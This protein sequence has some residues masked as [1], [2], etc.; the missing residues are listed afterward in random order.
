MHMI[1]FQGPLVGAAVGA[2]V[3]ELGEHV[4]PN[5]PSEHLSAL[6]RHA[7]QL[8]I[9]HEREIKLDPLNINPPHRGEPSV[10]AC[11]GQ[12]IADAR[13]QGRRQPSGRARPVLKTGDSVPLVGG[14]S[15]MPISCPLL[16]SMMY[17]FSAMGEVR[18]V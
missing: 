13:T 4:C 7:G 15:P 6:I 16:Q 10:A 9:L 18:Q 5:F 2:L 3:M 8:G 12:Y 11:P 17:S 14:S 1:Q